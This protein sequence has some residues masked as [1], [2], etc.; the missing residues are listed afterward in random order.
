MQRTTLRI[1]RY[2]LHFLK[3]ARDRDGNVCKNVNFHHLVARF[4]WPKF[5]QKD[6]LIHVLRPLKWCHQ[7]TPP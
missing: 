7:M 4:Q 2:P 6:I 5:R 3:I 1:L